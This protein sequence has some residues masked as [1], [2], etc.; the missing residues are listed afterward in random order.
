MGL[1]PKYKEEQYKRDQRQRKKEK[2][3]K[4]ATRPGNISFLIVCEGTKTEP[5]YFEALKE[6]RFSKVINIEVEGSGRGTVSLIRQTV[7]IRN[8]SD[9]KFDR[10]WAVFDKDDFTDFNEAIEL[11]QK[12]KINCGWSN[13]S[14]ELWYYLH[15]QY[16]DTGISRT[17]YIDKIEREIRKRSKD[18]S[19]HYQKNDPNTYSILQKYGDENLACEYAKKLQRNF[20]NKD[21]ASHKPCTTVNNLIYEMEHPESFF[22]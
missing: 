22:K 20:T 9:K 17:Q 3:R 5:N 15:F 1:I 12:K 14:F 16:L 13:E 18:K 8:K 7:K 21:Y 4:V 6:N 2:K 10:V 19:Y 11:A